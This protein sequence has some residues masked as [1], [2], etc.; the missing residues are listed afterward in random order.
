MTSSGDSWSAAGLPSTC[1]VFH[2]QA[3]PCRGLNLLAKMNMV[4]D[5]PGM[6]RIE[7]VIDQE[8]IILGLPSMVEK[9]PL[10]PGFPQPQG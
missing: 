4:F 8:A 10:P 1:F 5:R 6:G 3:A 7:V 9:I 2:V